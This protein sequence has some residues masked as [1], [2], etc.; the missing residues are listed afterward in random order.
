MMKG[1]NKRIQAAFLI[2]I[3][4]FSF[5][6]PSFAVVNWD[7][8][9]ITKQPENQSIPYGEPITLHVEI[10]V[11]LGVTPEF[12][13]MQGSF[14]AGYG[15]DLT[16]SP[17]GEGYYPKSTS[18]YKDHT[19]NFRCVIT[20]IETDGDGK[21]VSRHT[22]NSTIAQVTILAQ[23]EKTTWDTVQEKWSGFWDRVLAFVIFFVIVPIAAIL[24]PIIFFF[25]V[26][27][28]NLK[29]LVN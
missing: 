18:P 14:V 25:P 11:P 8:F 29:G 20:A 2:F 4:V 6:L 7:E 12:K 22:L 13:W 27:F 26:M 19:V 1:N 15:N 23:R 16:L 5:S 17:S 10:G 9:A 3:I 21:V 24:F 28:S